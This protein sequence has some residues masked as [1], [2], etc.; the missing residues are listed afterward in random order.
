MK[1]LLPLAAQERLRKRLIELLLPP[2]VRERRAMTTHEQ[3]HRLAAGTPMSEVEMHRIE[4][5]VAREV[6]R[7]LPPFVYPDDP[8]DP[9]TPWLIESIREDLENPPE[10]VSPLPDASDDDVLDCHASDNDVLDCLLATD[11][12]LDREVRD[13]IRRVLR[14]H[15]DD[16]IHIINFGAHCVRSMGIVSW[17]VRWRRP[18]SAGSWRSSWGRGARA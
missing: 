2:A 3:L 8:T 13:Y 9:D 5:E 14:R 6:D 10:G 11:L 7:C 18:G 1:R 17:F 12:E 15:H 4:S 16:L